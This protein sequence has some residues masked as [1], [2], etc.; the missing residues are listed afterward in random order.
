MS[1]TDYISPSVVLAPHDSYL[2]SGRF[3]K[4]NFCKGAG[5]TT[6]TMGWLNSTRTIAAAGKPV[7]QL[8]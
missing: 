3:P 6:T 1:L 7:T 5:H 8:R 4:D 2:Y